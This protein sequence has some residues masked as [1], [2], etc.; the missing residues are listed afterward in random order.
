MVN[1]S[2]PVDHHQALSIEGPALHY[3][4]QYVAAVDDVKISHNPKA[5]VKFGLVYSVRRNRPIA[6]IR[7]P[8]S[9]AP[10]RKS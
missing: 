4:V 3:L 10:T 7:R 8:T 2:L 1:L 5:I 9:S 6:A